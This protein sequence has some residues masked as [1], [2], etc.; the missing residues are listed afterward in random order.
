MREMSVTEQRYK[1]VQG[2]LADGRTVSEVAGDWGVCRRTMHRWL[3]RYEGAGLPALDDRS[4]R[5][6]HCPHQMPAAIEV[7]VLEM[8]RAHGYWGARRIAFELARKGVRPAPSES[9]VYRCL[10]R[11]AVIDPT[12]RRRRRE[13]WKRWERGAAM[14]LWQFDVVHGF[15]LADG[16]SAKALTG[17]DDHSRFCVSARLMARERTQAV[18]DGFSSALKAYGVPQQVLTDNGKV[19]TGRYAQPPVEVL[20]DRICRENGIDHILT[21]PRKPTTTGK[22]ERFHRSLRTEFDTRQR[23]RNL[24]TAQ[25]A[26]DEWVTYYN[27]QRPHQAL[28]D[29]TPEQRFHSSDGEVRHQPRQPERNGEQWVARRVAPNGIVCVDSQHVSVGKHY[30]GG[31]CDVLVTPGLFQFW[32]GNE[33]LKTVARTKSGEVRKKHAEG[34]APRQR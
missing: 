14:E 31:T 8:R 26:L 21:L 30:G 4:H 34:T 16:T 3:A 22:I 17:I 19:F 1:A 33:L 6:V 10:V 32:V 29:L 28:D 11:A 7:M 15:L 25:E 9:A 20:F 27:T 23:F 18:C 2:V 13:T 24:K 5:P 12:T